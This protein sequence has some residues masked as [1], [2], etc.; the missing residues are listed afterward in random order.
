MEVEMKLTFSEEEIL[1]MC[2][3]R[4]DTIETAAPGKFKAKFAGYNY[5]RRVEV[6]FVPRD[7]YDPDEIPAPLVPE[8]AEYTEGVR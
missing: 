4:C 3:K 5:D 1:A 8:A 6:T 7:V 2:L